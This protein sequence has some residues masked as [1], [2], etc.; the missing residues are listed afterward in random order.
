MCCEMRYKY[1]PNHKFTFIGWLVIVFFVSTSSRTFQIFV[2]LLPL[3]FEY[4][5][6]DLLLLLR[7]EKNLLVTALLVLFVVTTEIQQNL[8]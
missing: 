3:I 2:E 4:I 1:H 7:W 6:L 8:C 5:F